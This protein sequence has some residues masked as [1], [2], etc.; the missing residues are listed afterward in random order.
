[1]AGKRELKRSAVA[2]KLN[3][4]KNAKGNDI[5]KSVNLPGVVGSPEES[6]II[7]ISKVLNPCFDKEVVSIEHTRVDI[8]SEA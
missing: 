8:I 1:M 2:F 7:S 3:F 4:G 6:E 5:I